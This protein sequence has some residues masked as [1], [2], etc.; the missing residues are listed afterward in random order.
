[1]KIVFVSH[2]FYSPYFV[3][4]SHHLARQMARRGHTVWHVSAIPLFHLVNPR[5]DYQ[6]RVRRFFQ[7]VVRLEPNLTEAVIRPLFPWQVTRSFPKPGNYFVKW[8]DVDLLIRS[9]PELKEVD[10]LIL[11]EPRLSGME[12]YIHASSIYYRPTDLYADLK[13]DRTIQEAE[14]AFLVGCKGLVA[15]SE[16]VLERMLTLRKEIPHL[17]LTNGV[18]DAFA[19]P[20]DEP[21]ALR[22][23][24]RPRVVFVG[25]FEQRLDIAAIRFLA[26][27]FPA[28]SFVII[29]DGFRHE[30][31]K[32]IAGENMHLLGL[33][34]HAQLSAYLQHCDVG[35]L[36]LVKIRSNEGRSPMKLYEYAMSGLTVLASRTPELDRR[37]EDF[38]ELYSDYEEAARRLEAIL[39]APRDRAAIARQCARHSWSNKAAV[40]EDFIARTRGPSV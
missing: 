37:K 34:P 33:V 18:D 8:S 35:L 29:G 16:P 21:P 40:L 4:S 19:S 9:H 30:E 39:S 6:V 12:D 15:T 11:D 32:A 3:V 36:P 25:A 5:R 20:Q 7:G 31:M 2:S 14:A 22:G 10:V 1:M 17:V 38:I 23:L 28:V 26:G 13:N 24:G 27:R